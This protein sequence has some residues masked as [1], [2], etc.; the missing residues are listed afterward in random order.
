MI[1]LNWLLAICG[2]AGIVWYRSSSTEAW[3]ILGYFVTLAIVGAASAIAYYFRGRSLLL[4]AGGLNG[5]AIG[6]LVALQ[7]A[8]FALSPGSG[9]AALPFVVVPLAI[10]FTS[11]R[12][13]SD[14]IK[15]HG[16]RP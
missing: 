8:A 15:G 9:I 4:L 10:N 3:P 14:E 5:I 6:L 11:L 16:A 7:V 1:L 2:A 12:W 13:I